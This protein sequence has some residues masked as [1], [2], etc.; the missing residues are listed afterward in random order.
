MHWLFRIQPISHLQQHRTSQQAYRQLVAD[1]LSE[2]E[3]S[4]IRAYVQQQRALGS[5][6]FQAMIEAELGDA[7]IRDPPSPATR[8]AC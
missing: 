6:R 5:N 1:A 3:L 2:D 4:E 7:H 8:T